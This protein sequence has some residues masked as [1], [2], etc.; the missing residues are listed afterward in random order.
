[1]CKTSQ[2]LNESLDFVHVNRFSGQLVDKN[3]PDA[4]RFVRMDKNTIVLRKVP[5]KG[6]SCVGCFFYGSD[7]F[8]NMNCC[9]W[10]RTNKP[11]ILKC[12]EGEENFIFQRIK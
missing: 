4:E 8:G 6:A 1:M 5:F 12:E 11:A 2:E 7:M 3:Y 9:M 10:N